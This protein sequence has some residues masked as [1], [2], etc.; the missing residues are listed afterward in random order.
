MVSRGADVFYSTWNQSS[1][2]M[3]VVV[4][5]NT[6]KRPLRYIGVLPDQFY[7]K[8]SKAKSVLI[9]AVQKRVDTA[10]YDVISYGVAN[11]SYLDDLDGQNGIFGHEY[12]LKDG[13]VDFLVPS[14]GSKYIPAILKAEAIL[15]SGKI[16]L[17]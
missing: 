13:G 3:D 8:S 1:A 11:H 15:K 4:A 2:V 7:L 10:A 16:A 9:A 5:G 17:N 12:A 6:A 14:L